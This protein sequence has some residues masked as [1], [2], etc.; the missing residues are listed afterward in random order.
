MKFPVGAAL[1]LSF[2]LGFGCASPERAQPST[3]GSADAGA[4]RPALPDAPTPTAET[5][6]AKRPAYTL[7]FLKTGPADGQVVG[8]ERQT[9]FQG[10]MQNI[11]ALAEARRLVVAGPFGKARHDATLRGLF[12]M[13]T[14]DRAL[15]TEW[16]STDPTSKLGMFVL[17][18]H[19]FD[20]DA[21]LA[22][23]LERDLAREAAAKAGG[24]T[25]NPMENM[26]GYVLLT[27]EHG[28][29]ARRE[30]APLM[31]Q[32]RV[33][34]LADLEAGRAVAWLDAQNLAQAEE[35]FG[36]VLARVGAHALD[37]WF[38]SAELSRLHGH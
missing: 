15:A 32:G 37:E 22:A 10:H 23:A 17:E 6:V 9:A 8:Q 1:A 4:A 29:V 35:A 5:P 36:E 31:A 12:V 13:N 14:G 19:D 27:A 24:A 2:V 3:P 28:D 25:P 20:T 11:G 26:R 16:A 30:L 21:P 18:Y 7:V 34:L 38:G 33:F